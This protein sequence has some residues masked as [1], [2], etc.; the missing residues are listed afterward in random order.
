[1]LQGLAQILTK[2]VGAR[3]VETQERLSTLYEEE[4]RRDAERVAEQAR[5][6]TE[7]EIARTLRKTFETIDQVLLLLEGV[8]Q[9]LFAGVDFRHYKPFLDE[10]FDQDTTNTLETSFNMFDKIVLPEKAS[11][12]FANLKAWH[13]SI[14]RLSALWEDVFSY[15]IKVERNSYP[16]SFQPI[17]KLYT[18]YRALDE[19]T[20]SKIKEQFHNYMID[21]SLTISHEQELEITLFV[22]ALECFAARIIVLYHM[23]SQLH[24]HVKQ[25]E[26]LAGKARVELLEV[27]YERAALNIQNISD[28]DIPYDLIEERDRAQRVFNQFS[29]KADEITKAIAGYEEQLLAVKE[30]KHIS[31]DE[32]MENILNREEF[33]AE[34][35]REI[36]SG[37]VEIDEEA[38]KRLQAILESAA[39]KLLDIAL[40]KM[41]NLRPQV[42]QA[43][44]ELISA[45]AAVL[46][47]KEDVLKKKRELE[48]NRKVAFAELQ[49]RQKSVQELKQ[50]AYTRAMEFFSEYVKRLN[51]AN[52]LKFSTIIQAS[53]S[54]LSADM[55]N[56][57]LQDC[58][59]DLSDERLAWIKSL[60]THKVR[61][62][63]AV[64]TIADDG[65]VAIVLQ[66]TQHEMLENFY[67]YVNGSPRGT[68]MISFDQYVSSRILSDYLKKVQASTVQGMSN[69][70]VQLAALLQQVIETQVESHA[71]T[72]LPHMNSATI[73]LFGF[74]VLMF[75][76]LGR[77]SRLRE[78]LVNMLQL[79]LG[80]DLQACDKVYA[81]L[82]R[83]QLVE[84][85]E[86]MIRASQ[87]TRTPSIYESVFSPA[88]NK[89]VEILGYIFSENRVE[90]DLAIDRNYPYKK[91]KLTD[92]G[93]DLLIQELR[94]P[95][96][97]VQIDA[98]ILIPNIDDVIYADEEDKA[99]KQAEHNIGRKRMKRLAE[100]LDQLPW[101]CRSE[102]LQF[103]AIQLMMIRAQTA[104][105]Q[106]K[107][108]GEKSTHTGRVMAKVVSIFRGDE[109]LKAKIE[110]LQAIFADIHYMYTAHE[111]PANTKLECNVLIKVYRKFHQ[112]NKDDS[113]LLI[114]DVIK[115]WFDKNIVDQDMIR[116]MG[117]LTNPQLQFFC[118]LLGPTFLD[119]IA[120]FRAM[121]KD[122]VGQFDRIIIDQK[123]SI[124]KQ[125]PQTT[126]I[127]SEGQIILML[128]CQMAALTFKQQICQTH[129]TYLIVEA[130]RHNW[131]L[132]LYF[133][134]IILVH[135]KIL[136]ECRRECDAGLARVRERRMLQVFKRLI[137]HHFHLSA[138]ME[139]A[140][141]NGR[142][143]IS[144]TINDKSDAE[145][146]KGAYLLTVIFFYIL[147]MQESA[148]AAKSGNS[149]DA[150]FF[151][152][153]AKH[154]HCIAG[155]MGMIVEEEYKAIFFAM[156]IHLFTAYSEDLLLTTGI[157][158]L[159]K[160]SNPAGVL[161]VIKGSAQAELDSG[162]YPTARGVQV[163][164]LN[165]V[166]NKVFAGDGAEFFANNL[167]PD[168]H[169][170]SM[171]VK[172]AVNSAVVSKA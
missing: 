58:C 90:E 25:I 23:F 69:D 78:S 4:Q 160:F 3:S 7:P 51:S 82:S 156:A 31:I 167:R 140:F 76:Y 26:M 55:L 129:N 119:D 34:Q 132:Q 16:F 17:F 1:M 41:E 159:Q 49:E 71:H 21:S 166:V 22:E 152:E 104:V 72:A 108:F 87:Y 11:D 63:Q 95:R 154:F 50:Q 15:Y 141:S 147:F 68:L 29:K 149:S 161:N 48:A 43:K 121:N 59:Q 107:L 18:F 124:I 54:D 45:A 125:A 98:L 135:K 91:V 113:D 110:F 61:S 56:L 20:K 99:Q 101:R 66:D 142:K 115:P 128:A 6:A 134:E 153:L 85:G 168:T 169:A 73:S 164:L 97:M 92:A 137:E 40:Q 123:P 77:A 14:I 79:M 114:S 112:V 144:N 83:Q 10:E 109:P 60:I 130:S 122:T 62:L 100:L 170:V 96:Y 38:S 89:A 30:Y 13:Q 150:P 19:M 172:L 126:Q 12:I 163:I 93:S 36:F 8:F 118:A 151:L 136:P 102:L 81:E 57:F 5:L 155:M 67:I 9:E 53:L 46:Q 127:V 84:E 28:R 37:E 47:A 116:L 171:G 138:W 35:V 131:F 65:R 148:T 145:L 120:R 143:D 133:L 103:P 146:E 165:G 75:V 139:N 117:W 52:E 70:R 64:L 94:K 39:Q 80:Y 2:T 74:Y 32:A 106:R 86:L 158:A 157:E 162:F 44:H 33:N 88:P 24:Q 27:G 111:K 105:Y 42:E